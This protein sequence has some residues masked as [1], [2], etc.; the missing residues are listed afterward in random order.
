MK[1][2]ISI[3]KIKTIFDELGIENAH[4]I[5]KNTYVIGKKSEFSSIEIVSLFS[6]LEEIYSA[7]GINIDLFE[8]I[9]NDYEEPPE[10]TIS[11]LLQ[12][13][14]DFNND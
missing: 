4:T 3:E 12:K 14:S 9:F 2:S 11:G 10:L 13:I 7:K 6:S 5:N 8:L 1:V